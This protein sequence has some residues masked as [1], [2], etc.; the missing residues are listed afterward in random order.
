[1]RQYPR[2]NTGEVI[3]ALPYRNNMEVSVYYNPVDPADS[4]LERD[5]LSS[6]KNDFL[7]SV[8]ILMFSCVLSLAWLLIPA[9]LMFR[10]T[11]R[12]KRKLM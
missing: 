3:S 11:S 12:I 1:M 8:G 2:Q 7:T 4:V 10:Q 6:T 5:L 9:A